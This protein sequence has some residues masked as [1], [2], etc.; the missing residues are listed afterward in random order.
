MIAKQITLKNGLYARQA[1][2]FVQ[3]AYQ[4]TSDIKINKLW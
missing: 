2:S 1:V 4:F 3:R